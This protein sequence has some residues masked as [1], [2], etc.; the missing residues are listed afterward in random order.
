[1]KFSKAFTM[2]EI[3]LVVG[4][5]A[6]VFAMSAPYTLNFYRTQ[7]L[8]EA[9]SNIIDALQQAKHNAI[10]QKN[11]SKFGVRMVNGSYTLFQGDDYDTRVVEQSLDFDLISEISITGLTEVTFSKL[12][13][14]PSAVGT[15]TLTYGTMIREILIGESGI[16]TEID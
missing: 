9:R 11:D 16:I 15:T 10:L 14:S 13:G 4:I 7:M 8:E 1:M 2:I 3:L 12:T 5:A 6:G